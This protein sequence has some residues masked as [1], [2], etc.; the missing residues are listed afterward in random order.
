MKRKGTLAQRLLHLIRKRNAKFVSLSRVARLPEFGGYDRAGRALRMLE[1]AGQLEKIARGTFLVIDHTSEPKL[2]RNLHWSNSDLRDP[3][4]L[5]AAHVAKPR[6]DE[7]RVL[8]F[9]YGPKKVR[10]VLEVMER[11][12]ELSAPVINAAKR[13]LANIEIGFAHGARAS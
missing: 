13:A 4:T 8:A 10:S 11:E 3:D 7:L 2:P 1:K 9:H 6:P 12:Q 5:I